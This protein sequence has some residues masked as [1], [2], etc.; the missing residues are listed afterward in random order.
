VGGELAIEP[1]DASRAKTIAGLPPM[2][3][4]GPGVWRSAAGWP[5]GY[6]RLRRSIGRLAWSGD[7]Q[8]WGG[9]IA[10]G[11]ALVSQPQEDQPVG[12][13]NQP[14]AGEAVEQDRCQ[15]LAGPQ[16]GGY[17]SHSGGTFGDPETAGCDVEA[18][19]DDSRA[20]DQG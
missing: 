4:R 13:G 5:P 8:D 20:V 11:G 3:S 14:E 9:G 10:P 17:Q 6:R 18:L 12:E 15:C 1:L 2:V 7:W 19:R 16:P